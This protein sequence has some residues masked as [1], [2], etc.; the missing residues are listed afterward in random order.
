MRAKRLI[1]FPLFLLLSL[2]M[3]SHGQLWSGIISPSRSVDWTVVGLPNQTL[4]DSSWSQC[5]S[6]IGAYSGTAAAINNAL[7]ACGANQ[8]VLL[9]PGTFTLSTGISFP[10]NTNGH[11]ALRGSGANS[12]FLVFTGSGINCGGFATALICVQSSDGTYPGGS[13]TAYNWTGGYSQGSTQVILSSVAGI[14]LNQTLLVLN[15][16]DTGF[17]G[18]NCGSGSSVDNGN[19]FVCAKQYS[20]SGPTGCSFNG[21]DGTSWRGQTSWQQEWVTAIAINQG[22]CGSTCVTISQ[23][24]KHPNWA[25]SQS[26]QAVLIQPIPQ[27]GIE[28]LAIDGSSASPGVGIFFYNAYQGWVSGVKIT[29]IST[30]FINN[31]NVSHMQFENNYLYHANC[32]PGC[33]PYGIRI[34]SGGD[35]LVVNNIIEQVRIATSTDGPSA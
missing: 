3:Y 23:P 15:Q 12:T 5:G 6:T 19:Y 1:A 34:Q 13:T 7:A 32:A 35:N 26:P 31:V 25:S 21:P 18:S 27:D 8:Y 4:P 2:S 9:G 14:K 33:D 30:W 20:S 11:L 28:D 29:N 24:L 22:G 16:C 17:S 10:A